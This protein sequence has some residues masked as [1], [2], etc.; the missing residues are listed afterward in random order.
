MA[1]QAGWCRLARGWL[2]LAGR[3]AGPGRQAGWGWPA[4]WLGLAGRLAGAG[5]QADR[6]RR[7]KKRRNKRKRIELI[8]SELLPQGMRITSLCFKKNE[9]ETNDTLEAKGP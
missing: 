7:R 4:G 6:G 8:T 3:L 5:R 9:S 1:S 2:G